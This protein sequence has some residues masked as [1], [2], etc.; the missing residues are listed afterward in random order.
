MD[1][2][3]SDDR[4][5]PLGRDG[6]HSAVVRPEDADDP[7]VHAAKVL[8]GMLFFVRMGHVACIS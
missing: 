4:Q 8:V 2:F 7:S 3:G 6:N 5:R 1:S